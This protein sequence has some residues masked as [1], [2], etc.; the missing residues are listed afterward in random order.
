MCKEYS[1]T[2]TSLLQSIPREDAFHHISKVIEVTRVTIFDV[3]TQFRAVFSDDDPL[4]ISH[5]WSGGPIAHESA[6]FHSWL[7][8]KISQFLAT[9]EADLMRGGDSMAAR[10]D[11]LLGQCMYFGL[12]FGRVGCDFRGRLPQI[13]QSA[14]LYHFRGALDAAVRDFEDAINRYSFCLPV[15]SSRGS[16]VLND[17]HEV[18]PPHELLAFPPLS[19]L[20]N[21]LLTALNRLRLCSSLNLCREV[22]NTLNKSLTAC[23]RAVCNLHRVEG[24]AF[25]VQEVEA[26]GQLCEA[27]ASQLFP[28]INLCLSHLFP[29]RDL[30]AYLGLSRL[31]VERQRIGCLD[32][33]ALTEPLNLFLPQK[34]A[35]E[36]KLETE[37]FPSIAVENAEIATKTNENVVEKE[38]EK[39]EKGNNKGNSDKEDDEGTTTRKVDEEELSKAEE[40]TTEMEDEKRE[41]E[42]EEEEKMIEGEDEDKTNDKDDE[43]QQSNDKTCSDSLETCGPISDDISAELVPQ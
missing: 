29:Q 23:V 33:S 34:K 14:I 10:F 42:E 26:F 30:S 39:Q 2:F 19:L 12:S 4:V 11:T 28:H 32:L 40:E 6:L 21:H 41:V 35:I 37:P 9:L 24:S 7:C 5:D 43:S 13:F 16:K 3:I 8:L 38:E 17:A 15:T 36:E 18:P 1:F 25:S 22:V 20:T 31:E 27:M